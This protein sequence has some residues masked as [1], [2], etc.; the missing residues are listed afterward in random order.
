MASRVVIGS[1]LTVHRNAKFVNRKLN[2]NNRHLRRGIS[3]PE[4]LIAFSIIGV[5]SVMVAA[6]YFAQFRLFSNQN[7][8][9]DVST[10]ARL[11]VDEITNQLRQAESVVAGC[12]PCGS[13]TTDDAL[14]I[15]RAWPIDATG[16][17][18]DPAGANYDYIEFKVSGNKLIRITYPDAISSRASGTHIISTYVTSLV[19]TYDPPQADAAVVTAVVTTSLAAGNKTHTATETGKGTLRNK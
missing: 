8:A 19:F 16:E 18:M 11:A 1:K 13:D 9:I 15:L 7:T 3:L 2:T 6:I 10:Q 14:L 5:I 4:Y 12:P 17:P